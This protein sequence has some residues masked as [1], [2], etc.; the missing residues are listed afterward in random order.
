M[1]FIATSAREL[2]IQVDRLNSDQECDLMINEGVF[3][4]YWKKNIRF[5]LECQLKQRRTRMPEHTSAELLL[6]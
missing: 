5:Q 4:V 2:Q 1:V 3:S 6:A